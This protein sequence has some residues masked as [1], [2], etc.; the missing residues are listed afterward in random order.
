VGSFRLK[1]FFAYKQNKT[2]LDPFHMCFA[3]SLSNF[4]SLFSLFFASNFSLLFALVIF[5]SKR[6]KQNSSL[7]F[8]FFSLF[9]V[10]LFFS[11][12]SL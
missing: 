5:A 7:F 10:F 9:A 2:K 4:T 8:C 12:F 1:F 11:L 6:S 3:I